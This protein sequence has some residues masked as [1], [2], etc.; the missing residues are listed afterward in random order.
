LDYDLSEHD[1]GAWTAFAARQG[2]ALRV[3]A[4]TAAL[5]PAGAAAGNGLP[6]EDFSLRRAGDPG[7]ERLRLLQIG[8]Y[9]YAFQG[10]I[11]SLT[12]IAILR[13][14]PKP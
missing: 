3:E 11:V 1:L 5:L 7:Q 2:G 14:T 6:Y 9:G 13:R 12:S 4:G 10:E 8:S